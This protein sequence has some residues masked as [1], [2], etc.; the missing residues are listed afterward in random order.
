MDEEVII[1][2]DHYH[3]ILLIIGMQGAIISTLLLATS[4]RL[5]AQ[6]RV[7]MVSPSA[8]W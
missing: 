7:D 3:L 8:V 5:E 1:G 4:I 6:V 2:Q